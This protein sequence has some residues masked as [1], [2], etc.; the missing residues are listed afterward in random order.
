M[1]DINGVNNHTDNAFTKLNKRDEIKAEQSQSDMF[2][3][4]MIANLRNQD[5]TSPADTG[6]FM[7][8]ISDMSMVEGITNL[9][10][11][12]EGLTSS[13]LSSQAALQASSMVGQTVFVASDTVNADPITGLIR[14]VAE[15]PTSASDVVISVFDANGSEVDRISMGPQSA[16]DVPFEW[17]LEEGMALNGY[18]F[19]VT[20][21]VNGEPT[22]VQVFLGKNVDSVTLGQNGIGMKINVADGDSVS[23]DEIKQ[24]G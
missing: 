14:G 7:Q 12:M 21:Q 17:Q 11:S 18:R 2:M 10:K 1:A 8:Q 19:E 3:Q 9:N 23:L 13:M 24:I 20:A 4:L 22:A 15:L 6:Q 5:P 16:G